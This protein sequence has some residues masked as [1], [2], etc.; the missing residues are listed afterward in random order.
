MSFTLDMPQPHSRRAAAKTRPICFQAFTNTKVM[1]FFLFADKRGG[2]AVHD[3]DGGIASG[4]AAF[5]P[6]EDACF[7]TVFVR[8]DE[9]MY[10][11][12]TEH[13]DAEAR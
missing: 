2:G 10:R 13:H 9:A 4:A 6:G 8:A 5:R 1:I 7:H 11:T 12:K 3:G